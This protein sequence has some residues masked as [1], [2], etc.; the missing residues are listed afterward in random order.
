MVGRDKIWA[1]AR[2]KSISLFRWTRAESTVHGVH[3]KAVWSNILVQYAIV[4]FLQNVSIIFYVF[5]IVF[6]FEY[7]THV[8]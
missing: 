6:M 1:H 4:E 2:K 7:I 3:Q 5:L 8:D